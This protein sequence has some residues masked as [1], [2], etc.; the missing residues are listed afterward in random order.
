MAKFNAKVYGLARH[1]ECST[2]RAV[3]T[4]HRHR[5]DVMY[6]SDGDGKSPKYIRS[7][8]I[9]EVFKRQ[10]KKEIDTEEKLLQVLKD[11][12]SKMDG[13]VQ[14]SDEMK[15]VFHLLYDALKDLKECTDEHDA[16]LSALAGS[17]DY[18]PCHPLAAAEFVLKFI[19]T[20]FIK[21]EAQHLEKDMLALITSSGFQTSTQLLARYFDKSRMTYKQGYV[22]DLFR[23]VFTLYYWPYANIE[24]FHSLSV[25]PDYSTSLTRRSNCRDIMQTHIPATLLGRVGIRE[26]RLR[27]QDEFKIFRDHYMPHLQARNGTFY[28]KVNEQDEAVRPDYSTSL[29][30][31]SNLCSV[32]VQKHQH[33]IESHT[34]LKSPS[35]RFKP[36]PCKVMSAQQLDSIELNF[37]LGKYDESLPPDSLYK[38]FESDEFLPPDSL[39]KD[40]ESE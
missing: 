5:Q 18:L 37:I 21:G 40:F 15:E 36:D 28:L 25:R 20:F 9:F 23:I 24:S 16:A 22:S 12:L 3:D 38:D 13:D 30:R 34:T 1:L 17:A 2:L 7:S 32:S 29:T 27:P 14:L 11:D 33:S 8:I 26:C 35:K 31:R 6:T 10:L 4:T 19:P 39:H